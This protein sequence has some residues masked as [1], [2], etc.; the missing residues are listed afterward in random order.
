MINRFLPSDPESI[1]RRRKRAAPLAVVVTGAVL[2]T[3]GLAAFNDLNTTHESAG[4]KKVAIV[5]SYPG[6]MPGETTIEA[7]CD[8][9][10]EVAKQ[11]GLDDAARLRLGKE[12]VGAA[13]RA[14]EYQSP[15]HNNITGT[16]QEVTV[17]R[18]TAPLTGEGY[19]VQVERA[20]E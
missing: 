1:R 5:P 12:C 10:K 15:V 20:Q 9:T 2:T 13:Q 8:A 4:V 7:I 18:T 6:Q 11:A 16:N 19:I 3:G 14:I 17:T